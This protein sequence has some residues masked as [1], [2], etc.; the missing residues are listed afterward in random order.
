MRRESPGIWPL[1]SPRPCADHSPM[2]RNVPVAAFAAALTLLLIP[3]SAPAAGPAGPC[4]G[5]D[6]SSSKTR[7]TERA[8][9]CL[10]NQER[11]RAGLPD[12]HWNRSLSHAARQ[13]S[14]SMVRRRFFSHTSSNGG[15]FATR[16]R[17]AGYSGRAIGENIA[18]GA[19]DR[20]TPREIV[21]AW[22]H[23]PGHRRNILNPFFR[24]IGVGVARGAPYIGVK[25]ARMYTTDFGG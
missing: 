18:W 8:T 12:L 7:T 14:R 24:R 22:M 17:K 3:A 19:G 4:S 16:I 23:S 2:L 15:D 13:H 6:V 5:A 21:Q 9:L 10:L 20:G 1:K 11:R 25:D